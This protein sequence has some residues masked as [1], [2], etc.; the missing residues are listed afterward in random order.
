VE[1]P[2]PGPRGPKG[3]RGERGPPGQS[4]NGLSDSDLARIAAWPGVKVR[5][6]RTQVTNIFQGEK[7]ECL[8]EASRGPSYETNVLPTESSYDNRPHRYESRFGHFPGQ[9]GQKGEEID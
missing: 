4:F 5:F 7:G 8:T 9:K 3:D 2:I 1:P 6:D